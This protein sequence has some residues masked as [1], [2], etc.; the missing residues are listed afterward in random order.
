MNKLPIKI[1]SSS[2]F[3]R[4]LPYNFDES[5]SLF[6]FFKEMLLEDVPEIWLYTFHN[7]TVDVNSV[8]YNNDGTICYDIFDFCLDLKYRRIEEAEKLSLSKLRTPR[9]FL[10]II[11]KKI[12]NSLNNNVIQTQYQKKY[13]LITDDRANNNFF[14]WINE[15]MLR[16]VS[17]GG[18]PEESILLVPEECW[19][20]EYVRNSLKVFN[21]AEDQICIIPKN[22]K[23]K[24]KQLYAVS[25][26]MHAPGASNYPLMYQLKKKIEDFYVKQLTIDL[27]D[28]IY[29]SREKSK[30]RKVANEDEVLKYLTSL[31]FTKICAED[32]S[33]IELISIMKHTKYCIGMVSAGLTHIMFMQQGGFI[34]ELIHEDFI[35]LSEDIWPGG[36]TEKYAGVHYYSLANAL[37]LKYLYQPSNRVHNS[38]Y[39]P[40]DDI[41]VDMLKLQQNVEL[42]LLA[43]A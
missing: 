29:I 36:Y 2:V 16:L 1:F 12:A 23:V 33:L 42:M 19:K 15:A 27:G 10:Q 41:K 20:Y 11:K 6:D 26:S 18:L 32:Y 25:C 13:Y 5:N 37:G 8:I 31:G 34:L 21:I 22:G 39:I 38:N 28:K 7:V 24:L 43:N 4:E 30:H 40:A 17:L 35:C 9:G 14:H 3:K